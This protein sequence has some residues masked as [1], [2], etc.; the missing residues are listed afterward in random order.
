MTYVD[1]LD[2]SDNEHYDD[3]DDEEYDKDLI[4]YMDYGIHEMR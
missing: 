4:K 3:N 2:Y 1:D